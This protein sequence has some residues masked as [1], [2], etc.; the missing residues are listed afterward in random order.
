[1][2]I[3]RLLPPMA[4]LL[5]LPVV[6]GIALALVLM[7]RWGS[8]GAVRTLDSLTLLVLSVYATLSA[9]L[10]ARSA[11]GSGRRAW[12]TMAVA[13]AAWTVGGL[14]WSCFAISLGHNTFPSPADGCYIAFTLLAGLAMALFPDWPLRGSRLRIMLD[15]VTVML[16]LFLLMWTVALHSTYHSYVA[17]GRVIPVVQLLFPVGDLVVLTTALQ[18]VVRAE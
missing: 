17:V 16:C 7:F 10:A 8:E 4:R 12:T 6:L 3:R 5:A 11:H 15:G 14:I 13:L 1:V 2:S 18:T 9:V